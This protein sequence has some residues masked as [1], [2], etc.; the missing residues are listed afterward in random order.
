MTKAQEYFENLNKTLLTAQKTQA[1]KV[2]A[3]AQICADALASDGY[4]YTF[5]TGHSHLL[6][7]EIFYRAGGLVRIFPLEDD[8]L[9][10]HTGASRSSQFERVAGFASILL[11]SSPAKAGDVMFVF[12]NSGRNTMPV[13]MALKARE[14]G[15]KTICITSFAHAA[16]V[17]SRHESGK[18]LGEVCDVSLDNCG[19]PGDACVALGEQL[20]GPTSTVV[21]AALLQAIVCRA[22]EILQ[23]RGITPEIFAS[24]NIDGGDRKNAAY[25]AKYKEKINIL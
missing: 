11:T 10:L 23:E 22:A 4:L 20:M 2:E 15:L 17:S 16:T 24:A 13:E 6:A 8:A 5:G 19:S 9:M 7:E 12:S 18:K 3:A 14:L 1:D 25:L 21:G